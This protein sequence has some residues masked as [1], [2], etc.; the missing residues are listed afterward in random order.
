MKYKQNNPGYEAY[1]VA[2]KDDRDALKKTND[3]EPLF[4]LSSSNFDSDDAKKYDEIV[5]DLVYNH[6]VESAQKVIDLFEELFG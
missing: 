5:N 4:N 1:L 6:T 2:G 3:D